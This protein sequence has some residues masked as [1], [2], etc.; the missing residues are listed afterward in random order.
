MNVH[1]S[2]LPKRATEAPLFFRC[3][4]IDGTEAYNVQ[5]LSFA[6]C[7][8]Q[9]LKVLCLPGLD[10]ETRLSR[11]VR[12]CTNWPELAEITGYDAPYYEPGATFSGSSSTY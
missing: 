10:S 3:T 5:P 12:A 4:P 11:R 7:K 2:Q 8:V 1:K 9:I 6:Q